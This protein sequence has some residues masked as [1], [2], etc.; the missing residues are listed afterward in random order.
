MK[1]QKVSYQIY[2]VLDYN[3]LKEIDYD[4]LADYR[5]ME[6]ELNHKAEIKRKQMTDEMM[7]KLKEVGNSFLG[8]FGMS[9]DN[10]KF[11][12]GEGGGYSVQFQK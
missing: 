3:K 11:N 10:F 8:I 5:I 12:Q 9:T 6:R 4:F 2:N 1:H 7:G